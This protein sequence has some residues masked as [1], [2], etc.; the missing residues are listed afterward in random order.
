MDGN[1]GD[2][3]MGE[4]NVPSVRIHGECVLCLFS[5]AMPALSIHSDTGCLDSLASGIVPPE[6]GQSPLP[7]PSLISL[8]VEHLRIPPQLAVGG[9]A[10]AMMALVGEQRKGEPHAIQVMAMQGSTAVHEKALPRQ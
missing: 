3:N 1:M 2:G 9:V 7:P 8:V 10:L 6:A 5:L 4:H